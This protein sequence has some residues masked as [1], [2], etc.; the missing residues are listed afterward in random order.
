[1]YSSD[2]VFKNIIIIAI[3]IGFCIFDSGFSIFDIG[4]CVYDIGF[5]AYEIIIA[6]D[7]GLRHNKTILNSIDDNCSKCEFFSARS[8]Q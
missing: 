4:F 2:N 8:D 3:D 7:I 1:M 5:C 6:I